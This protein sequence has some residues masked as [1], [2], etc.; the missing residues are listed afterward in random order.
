MIALLFPLRSFLL[1]EGKIREAAHLDKC[2]CV[3]SASQCLRA[4]LAAH[5]DGTR[6][7]VERQA[8]STKSWRVLNAA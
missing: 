5:L 8:R 4:S 2:G 3:E 6:G 1:C 7:G